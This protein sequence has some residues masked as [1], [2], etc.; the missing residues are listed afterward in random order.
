MLRDLDELIVT[1]PHGLMDA[2]DEG[3]RWFL[4]LG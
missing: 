2:V 3:V 1:L 4:D